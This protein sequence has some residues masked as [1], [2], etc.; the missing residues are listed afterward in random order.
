MKKILYSLLLISICFSG[1]ALAQ[2]ESESSTPRP[3]AKRTDVLTNKKG[4]PVLPE[5]GDYA[6]SLDASSAL[7]YLGQMLSNAGANAPVFQSAGGNTTVVGKY[8]T[9]DKK[10]YRFSIGVNQINQRLTAEVVDDLAFSQNPNAT[11]IPMTRDR[12]ITR[13]T[14]IVASAALETRIGGQRRIQ[15]FYGYGPALSFGLQSQRFNYGNEL[16]Q[17]NNFDRSTNFAVNNT[18]NGE[19]ITTSNRLSLGIGAFAYAG[20]EYFVAPKVSVGGFFSVN[21]FL[22]YTGSQNINTE[23][24]DGQNVVDQNYKTSDRQYNSGLSTNASSGIFVNLHF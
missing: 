11:E 8:F 12:S 20:A 15:G 9:S 2:E 1:S 13:N 3:S 6:I 14:S 10:A 21:L 19:D 7:D 17:Q 16:I 4:I 22:N 5:R 24:Y 23:Y 18:F